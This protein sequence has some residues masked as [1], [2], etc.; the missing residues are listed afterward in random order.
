MIGREFVCGHHGSMARQDFWRFIADVTK[1]HKRT[2]A[3]HD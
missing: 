2:E 3:D 1:H